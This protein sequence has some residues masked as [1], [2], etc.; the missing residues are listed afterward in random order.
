MSASPPI[1]IIL[2]DRRDCKNPATVEA[3]TEGGHTSQ[4]LCDK[5]AWQDI[6]GYVDKIRR[7]INRKTKRPIAKMLVEPG[8]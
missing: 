1:T 4:R 7:L 6:G 8:A 2:C 3:R 5:C